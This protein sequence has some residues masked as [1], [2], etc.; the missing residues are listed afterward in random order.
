MS[1]IRI[2]KHLNV[3]KLNEL[4]KKKNLAGKDKPSEPLLSTMKPDEIITIDSDDD[5]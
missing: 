1:A 3:L 4:K 2:E 5:D